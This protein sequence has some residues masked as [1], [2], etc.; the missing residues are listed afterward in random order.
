MTESHTEEAPVVAEPVETYR[1]EKQPET[2]HEPTEVSF[3]VVGP[4]GQVKV[5]SDDIEAHGLC[6][7]LHKA[8]EV[9]RK[10]RTVWTANDVSLLLTEAFVTHPTNPAAARGFIAAKLNTCN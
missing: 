4:E 2:L 7:L 8:V 5:L 1:V 10:R 3:A 6:E 9:E